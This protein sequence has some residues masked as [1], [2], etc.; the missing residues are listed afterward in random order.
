MKITGF[1][2]LI[3]GTY[4]CQGG[5][6]DSD[7]RRENPAQGLPA[8]VYRGA[9]GKSVVDDEDVAGMVPAGPGLE[10]TAQ[11]EGSAD[12]G[13]L[14]LHIHLCL[15]DGAAVTP[16]DVRADGR[17][18]RIAGSDGFG[19]DPGLVITPAPAAHPVKRHG[20]DEVHVCERLGSGQMPAEDGG[21]E[22]AGGDTAFI[23]YVAGDTF[24]EGVAVVEE[25]GG[26]I[27]VVLLYS[28]LSRRGFSFRIERAVDGFVELVRHR[29][30]GALPEMRER[31]VGQA[32]QADETLL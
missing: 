11:V 29:V 25:Q 9:G 23:L 1:Q 15:A 24:V 21:E 27:G 19:N 32:G 13:R 31:Q 6:R 5:R 3:T 7:G 17:T 2:P 16:D 10:G 20:N 26:S 8:G 28:L 18:G 14:G 30:V 4:E 12:I 22:T